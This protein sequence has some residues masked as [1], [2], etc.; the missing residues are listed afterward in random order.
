MDITY[1][2]AVFGALRSTVTKPLYK[3]DSG[4]ILQIAGITDL[5]EYFNAD[6]ANSEKGTATRMLGHDGE[7]IIPD[8]LLK[9]GLP[10][11]C[12]IYVVNETTGRTVYSVKIPVKQRSNVEDA[13]PTPEQADIITQA[14]TALNNAGDSAQQSASE[15]QTYAERAE[16]AS[17]SAEASQESATQ[18]A[19]A[20]QRS[21]ES[22][23][24]SAQQAATSEAKAK[25]Y[26]QDTEVDANRA[27][28]A[29][30]NAGYFDVEIDARGH[31][32]YTR[33]DNMAMD[34]SVDNRGHLIIEIGA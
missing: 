17:E 8:A 31:L 5:P 11:F 21:A 23:S 14:I 10:I 19:T 15:A 9:T 18:S 7:V 3:I 13:Q 4:V 24:Q 30:K 32:I 1:I 2:R 33:T 20:S 16:T 34:L 28:M 27:E 26:A 25:R 6:F 22:A 29:A 12:W